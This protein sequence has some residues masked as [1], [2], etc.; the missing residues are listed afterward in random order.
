MARVR[1]IMTSTLA[2][3][4]NSE[5]ELH[6]EASSVRKLLDQLSERFGD[7]FKHRVLDEN[8]NPK[9]FVVIYINGKNIQFAEGL[10][11]KLNDGDE[12]LILP[13]IGGGTSKIALII[14]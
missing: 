3:Y 14:V 7:A 1:L 12:V 9:S 6:M 11:T 2:M 8:G 10:D 13:A 4:L 5:R